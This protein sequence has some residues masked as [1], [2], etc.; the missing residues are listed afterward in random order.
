M[1][2]KRH[3]SFGVGLLIKPKA[4]AKY[5]TPDFRVSQGILGKLE[6]V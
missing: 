3:L 1:P 5:K 4:V 6:K 2:V